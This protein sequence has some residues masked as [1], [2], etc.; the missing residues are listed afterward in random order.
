MGDREKYKKTKYLVCEDNSFAYAK[1]IKISGEFSNFVLVIDGKQIE[2]STKLLG[3]ANVD[4]IVVAATMAYL[5]GESLFSIK[6]GIE[7]LAQIPHRLEFISGE[8]VDVI[9]DSYNSNFDGFLQALE[10]VKSFKG[11]KVVVSPG[12]VELGS[13]QFQNNFIVGQEVAKVADVFVIMNA[14]NKRALFEGA[15]SQGMK[16]EN[17][18][19]AHNRAEQKQLLKAILKKG[20]LVLFENDFPDNIK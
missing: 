5:L 14:T 10:I 1:E 2:C 3:K 12:L 6:R 9:D 4:N 11:R 8:F 20:D 13:Q 18:C 19:F 15:V 7:K 16:K 17:I